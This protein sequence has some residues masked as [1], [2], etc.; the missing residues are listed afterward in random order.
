MNFGDN[1]A[2]GADGMVFVL[3]QQ[4][5][6]AIGINGSGMGYQGFFPSFGIEFDTYSNNA[7]PFTG[8]NMGDPLFDHC[9]FLKSGDVNHA[10]ANNL[11]GPVQLSSTNANVEDGNDHIVKIT[12]DP[13]TETVELYFDCVLRLSD[14]IDLLGTIFTNNP[15]VFFGFTG[16]TGGFN[17]LQVVCLQENIIPSPESAS[18]CLGESITLNAGGDPGSTFSWSPVDGLSD[19]TI[20]NPVASPAVTTNYTVTLTD[21]CGNPIQREF[22]VIVL[23]PPTVDAGSD[24]SFCENATA[25]L[26]GTVTG[27]QNFSWVFVEDNI[28]FG[29]NNLAPTIS[30]VGTYELN[31]TNSDGCT[32]SDQVIVSQIPL[33]LI[34]L[35]NDYAICPDE[36]TTLLLTTIYDNVQW[37]TGE[38]SNSIEVAAGTY[39]VEV[40]T[41]TCSASD[42]II[43]TETVLPVINLGPDL[44]ECS[45]NTITLDA[46]T[47]VNW[48]NGESGN[49][50]TVNITGNYIAT[51]M[52]D[53]CSTSDDVTLTFFNEPVVDL[54]DDLFLCPDD[55]ITLNAINLAL[56]S[57][58]ESASSIEVSEAGVYT[59]TVTNGPC[60]VSD[61]IEIFTIDTP[62]VDL[63]EDIT[64]CNNVDY[65]LSAANDNITEYLWSTGSE[66]A[67]IEPQASG[68]YSVTVSNVCGSAS[69]TINVEIE[70]CDYFLFIP[71]AFT[72]DDDG[73]ND[74][75]KIETQNI[76]A[77][78]ITIV[79][80]WGDIVFFTKSMDDVWLGNKRDSEYYLHQGVYNY[81]IKYLAENG[82]AGSRR[83]HIT[84][85]R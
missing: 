14:N 39:S 64:I 32:A 11:A 41:N 26:N 80:R 50:I 84:L 2:E 28:V 18:V 65:I 27:Q 78:E 36:T 49:T 40:T 42:D 21:F 30:T 13:I 33:P 57:T 58:G 10:S 68:E 22:E 83:G 19:P 79:D 75:W 45:S 74:V 48:S 47:F 73:L 61:Q 56:W 15:N 38:T 59:A 4:G 62:F 51:A 17:N 23:D 20:Q 76:I 60:V 8:Q 12:W 31:A 3:Q 9:A 16:S 29:N 53:G 37:S 85:L 5:V 81:Y 7:D 70:E 71:N 25:S 72:P 67:F 54:G 34:D 46:G 24:F 35:G 82:D 43:I 44:S 77:V 63:G 1:D 6:N 55:T 66:G 69:D 52:V